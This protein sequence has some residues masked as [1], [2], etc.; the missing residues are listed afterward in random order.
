MRTDPRR[1]TGLAGPAPE[2]PMTTAD[3]RVS[4]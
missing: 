2:T 1:D 3:V 4:L